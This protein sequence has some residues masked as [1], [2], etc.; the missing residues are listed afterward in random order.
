MVEISKFHSHIPFL[1]S[2]LYTVLDMFRA[3]NTLSFGSIR[4]P[5]LL[6]FNERLGPLSLSHVRLPGDDNARVLDE[7]LIHV[8]ECSSGSLRVEEKYDREIEPADDGKY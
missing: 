6:C 2:P 4:N 5:P 8:F 1:Q 3:S 7:D